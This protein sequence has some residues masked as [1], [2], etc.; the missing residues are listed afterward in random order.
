MAAGMATF[1]KGHNRNDEQD[2]EQDPH[3]AVLVLATSVAACWSTAA[4]ALG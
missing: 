1:G 2:G 4:V 3:G